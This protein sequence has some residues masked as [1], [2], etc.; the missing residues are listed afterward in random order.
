MEFYFPNLCNGVIINPVQNFVG[1]CVYIAYSFT[2]SRSF[3]VYNEE[4]SCKYLLNIA[5][6][7][8]E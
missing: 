1:D 4:N 5:C 8:D 3:Q 2:H 7:L 6:R